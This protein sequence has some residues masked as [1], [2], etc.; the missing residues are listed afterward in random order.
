MIGAHAPGGVSVVPVNPGSAMPTTVK[1]APFNQIGRQT[2]DGSALSLLF[3]RRW[4]TTATGGAPTISSERISARPLA[5]RP[6]KAARYP[7][8]TKLRLTGVAPSP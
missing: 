8:L 6:R 2:I 3:Q 5:P 7:P 4:L 1:A